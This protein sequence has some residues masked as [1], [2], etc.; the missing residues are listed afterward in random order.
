MKTGTINQYDENGMRHGLWER[1]QPNGQP[2]AKGEFKNEKLIGL[3]YEDKY[4]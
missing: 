3:W 4:D 1:Y 2:W